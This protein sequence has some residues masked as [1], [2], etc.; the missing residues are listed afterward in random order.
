MK[1]KRRK[2]GG[3]KIKNTKKNKGCNL[4]LSRSIAG[5]VP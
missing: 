2:Y 3:G 5:Q 1:G 4:D